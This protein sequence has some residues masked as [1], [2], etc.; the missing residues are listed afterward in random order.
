MLSLSKLN[1]LEPDLAKENFHRCCGSYVWAERMTNLRPF[2]SV[3][4]LFVKADAVWFSLKKQDFLEAYSHHPQIGDASALKANW[5][6]QEQ[7]GVSFADENTLKALSQGNKEY[8]SKFGFVFLICATGK[9]ASEM[10]ESLQKRLQN[11]LETEI[12]N[13]SLETSKI[14]RIRLEKLLSES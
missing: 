10:L 11:D 5:T 6:S 8:F 14:T 3:T 4:D 7:T 1:S 12:K 13:A 2:E 9:Q